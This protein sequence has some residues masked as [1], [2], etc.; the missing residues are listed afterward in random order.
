MVSGPIESFSYFF[1]PSHLRK[2]A[3]KTQ[4]YHSQKIKDFIP[5]V[6]TVYNIH[7]VYIATTLVNLM[8]AAIIE[9][10]TQKIIH[11]SYFLLFSLLLFSVA[12]SASSSIFGHDS[13]ERIEVL[14][15][16]FNM[17]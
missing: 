9:T 4:Y 2:R 11:T 12:Q 8:V 3:T 14:A 15:L 5:K 1:G 6:Q 10:H 13:A 7:G 16:I 17:F